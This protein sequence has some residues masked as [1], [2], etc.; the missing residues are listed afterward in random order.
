MNKASAD[1]VANQFLPEIG[2]YGIFIGRERQ[3]SEIDQRLK[4][5][6]LV[7]LV[8]AGGMG[9]TRL[10]LELIKWKKRDPAQD[11][12]IAF[13]SFELVTA[14]SEE[15]ALDALVSGLKLIPG[16]VGAL[17]AAL[18]KR[19]SDTSVLLVL[20]NCETARSS[21]ASL[22]RYLL[23]QCPNLKILRPRSINSACMVLRLFTCFLHCPCL[24][25]A[26]DRWTTWKISKATN[27]SWPVRKWRR[28]RGCRK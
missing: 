28:H 23:N 13:V 5:H 18:V 15:A 3:L 11:G 19:I 7:T 9:K 6:R 25:I 27:S 26:P 4:D 20:D 2:S 14:N 10:A 24:M 21:I 8:G 1:S 22:V 16:D 12:P 17:R